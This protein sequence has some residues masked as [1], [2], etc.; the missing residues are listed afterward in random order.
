MSG[1]IDPETMEPTTTQPS[2]FS[3]RNPVVGEW[4]EGGVQVPTPPA[5]DGRVTAESPALSPDTGLKYR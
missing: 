3:D 5:S 2:V 4:G 1:K